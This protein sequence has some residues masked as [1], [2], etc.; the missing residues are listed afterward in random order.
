M[1]NSRSR[2]LRLDPKAIME[3]SVRTFHSV[4]PNTAWSIGHNP[5]RKRLN[6]HSLIAGLVWLALLLSFSA[7][8]VWASQATEADP[9][10]AA[11]L[12]SKTLSA[13]GRQEALLE[14]TGFGRYAV[15]VSSRQGTA[16]Q[17]ID[18]M[19]GPSPIMGQP[20][21]QDGRIDRFLDH[22][23]YK[24]V[25]FGPENG[26]GEANLEAHPFEA[27]NAPAPPLLLVELKP[28]SGSLDD[29][30]ELSYWV[31]VT[32]ARHVQWS[33]HPPGSCFGP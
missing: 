32:E 17:L 15:T 5:T 28:V 2:D 14:I 18:C 13:A 33:I 10:S 4:P 1:S 23:E 9:V 29:F 6:E 8:H 19:S 11:R 22:G 3:A 7:P 16:V 24:V 31:E 25:T 12:S 27:L 20:G 26:L 30:Q 21:E